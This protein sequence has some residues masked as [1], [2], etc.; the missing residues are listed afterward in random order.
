M[1]NDKFNKNNISS[2]NVK[3]SFIMQNLISSSHWADPSPQNDLNPML[4][5]KMKREVGAIWWIMIPFVI[6]EK[7]A[8]QYDV[9]RRC[10]DFELNKWTMARLSININTNYFIAKLLQTNA[11]SILKA[12]AECL[13]LIRKIITNNIC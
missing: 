13:L 6:Y 8:H 10:N 1:T 7:K 9:D 2:G 5:Q 11:S 12:V 4:I 3:K